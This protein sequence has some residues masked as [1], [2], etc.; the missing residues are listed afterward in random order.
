[1]LT[2]VLELQNNRIEDPKVIE[3][4]ESMPGLRVLNLMGNPVAGKIRNYRKTVTVRC[5]ELTYLDDRPVFPR[6]R[7]CAEAWQRGGIEAE[8]AERA[9]WQNKERLKIESSMNYLR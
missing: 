3:I 6:D 9:K 8:K 2:S 5:K 1:M 4:F 7:A